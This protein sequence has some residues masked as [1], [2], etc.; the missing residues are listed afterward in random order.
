MKTAIKILPSP[1]CLR[2]FRQLRKWDLYIR[3]KSEALW[4]NKEEIRF[5]NMRRHQP[6]IF[7]FGKLCELFAK[8]IK[9]NAYLRIADYISKF[10]LSHDYRVFLAGNKGR[11]LF[12]NSASAK[13][14]ILRSF[15]ALSERYACFS[16]SVCIIFSIVAPPLVKYSFVCVKQ[17]LPYE[18]R[19]NDFSRYN[20]CAENPVFY[21]WYSEPAQLVQKYIKI[22]INHHY[23]GG[24]KR[25]DK[26]WNDIS[27]SRKNRKSHKSVSANI[28]FQGRHRYILS[29]FADR[30]ASLA[31]EYASPIGSTYEFPSGIC[32]RLRFL[33]FIAFPPPRNI[34]TF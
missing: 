4:R 25:Y 19:R 3:K 21:F 9:K 32:H 7:N 26:R 1:P 23:P 27:A 16:F 28:A 24:H 2:I 20:S 22:F 29:A 31:A 12:E 33:R 15:K 13:N 14:D 18:M 34:F 17:Q 5:P 30:M 10:S 8:R 6:L 11:D